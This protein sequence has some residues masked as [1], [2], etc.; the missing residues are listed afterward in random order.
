MAD[1]STTY[2][3]IPLKSP[4]I[5]GASNLVTKPAI[6]KDL[7]ANGIGAVVYKSL[8]EE[9]IQLESLQLDEEL[10]EYANRNSEMGRLFPELEHAGPREHL[11]NVRKLKESLS[12]PVFASLNALYEPSWV[13]YARLLEETGVDGLEINLYAIPGYFEIDAH[14]IEEKQIQ[15]VKSVKKA[16][17]IPVSVKISPFYTNTMNF[18]KGISKNPF[19]SVYS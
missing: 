15:I 6:I 9:Q 19:F 14:L 18:I 7:E 16:V 4:I 11:F 12:V 5:L 3:G 13:G 1:L 2:M 10:T 17:K 8:F